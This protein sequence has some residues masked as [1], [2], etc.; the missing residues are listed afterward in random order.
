MPP[1]VG[2]PVNPCSLS[3]PLALPEIGGIIHPNTIVVAI[4]FFDF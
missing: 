4:I 2:T 1:G 3:P